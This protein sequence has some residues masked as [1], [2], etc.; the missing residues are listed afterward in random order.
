MK[1]KLLLV[2]CLVLS[3][4]IVGCKDKESKEETKKKISESA[5]KIG[6]EITC[7]QFVFDGVVYKFPMD[8]KDWLDNGWHISNS[9]ENKDEFTLEPGATSNEFELFNEDEDYV[10][11]SVMNTKDENAKIEDC[12]VY[13]L[14]MSTSEGD[15]VLPGGI[16]KSS[17]PDDVIEAYG[18]PVSRGD[19]K[20]LLEATYY[21]EDEDAWKCYVE[22]DVVD[23]NFTIDPISSV[24]YSIE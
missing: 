20:G 12:M 4:M 18:E 13:S 11:V 17:K 2:L 19:E 22:L 15:I 14:Y 10:R 6:K 8:L 9:Y 1:K 16:N 3:M 7:G 24:I 21:Y 23:N 5:E